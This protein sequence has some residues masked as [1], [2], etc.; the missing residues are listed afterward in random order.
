[1]KYV[2]NVLLS[3]TS[4]QSAVKAKIPPSMSSI[5]SIPYLDLQRVNATRRHVVA[6]RK[7]LACVSHRK[8]KQ[9][10]HHCKSCR[11]RTRAKRETK[12]RK[13]WN[14]RKRWNERRRSRFYSHSIDS[15]VNKRARELIAPEKTSRDVSETFTLKG[16]SY[17][18]HF[19][20]TFR[21]SKEKTTRKETVTVKLSFEP[22]NIQEA[23]P[24]LVHACHG[25]LW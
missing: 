13:K 5:P 4:S 16:S 25:N 9:P 2:D 15:I 11:W 8:H 21:S 23:N 3:L 7:G 19:Q 14:K 17:H 1:M 10:P 20:K 18:E 24:I 12:R 22:V 6:S